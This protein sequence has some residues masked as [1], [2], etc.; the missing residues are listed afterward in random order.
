MSCET[1]F[2][3]SKVVCPTR[4]LD[5]HLHDHIAD[6]FIFLLRDVVPMQACSVLLG[7]PWQLDKQCVHHGRTNQY[8]LVQ[9]TCLSYI[10][11]EPILMHDLSL[12]Q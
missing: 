5:I 6:I 10:V 8:T 12:S 9:F 3:L 7:R 4:N 11:D 1:T 2:T